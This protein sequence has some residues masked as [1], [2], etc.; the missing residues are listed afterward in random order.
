VIAGGRLRFVSSTIGRT[1]ILPSLN[2]KAAY[3][4]ARRTEVTLTLRVEDEGTIKLDRAYF[5]IV[6]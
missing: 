3:F 5:E 4:L 2:D 1:P 6:H